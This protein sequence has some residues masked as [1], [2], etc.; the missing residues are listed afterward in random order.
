[1]ED[2]TGQGKIVENIEKHT[3]LKMDKWTFT[4]LPISNLERYG[5]FRTFTVEW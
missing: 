3:I 4:N 2:V 1:M 5:S